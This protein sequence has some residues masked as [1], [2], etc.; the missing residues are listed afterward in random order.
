MK[1]TRWTFIPAL[2]I[3]ISIGAF[4]AVL[5]ANAKDNEAACKSVV[6]ARINV[7]QMSG[8][9]EVPEKIAQARKNGVSNCD[10]KKTV[11]DAQID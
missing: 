3:G 6:D 8:Q 10:L 4:I 7:Y 11:P 1:T 2:I 5:I 9:T